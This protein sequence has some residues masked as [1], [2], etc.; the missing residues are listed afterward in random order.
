MTK[1][2]SKHQH[3]PYMTKSRP[4]ICHF[5]QNMTNT[6]PALPSYQKPTCTRFPPLVIL[7]N[8]QWHSHNM[9]I[10]HITNN[11]TILL[12]S[13]N[14][15]TIDM[16][17]A[18]TPKRSHYASL[19]H[20]SHPP[21]SHNSCRHRCSETWSEEKQNTFLRTKLLLSWLEMIPIIL[22]SRDP[23]LPR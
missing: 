6:Q 20:I 2:T 9:T 23:L 10:P 21:I 19:H 14:N 16:L 17:F 18:S 4:N 13:T 7:H 3:A 12:C 11:T 5:S 15:T 22:V 8:S 1:H